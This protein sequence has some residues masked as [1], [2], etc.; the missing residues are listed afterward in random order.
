MIHAVWREGVELPDCG[1]WLDPRQ[2]V[3]FAFIS[4]AHSDHTAPHKRVLC[5]TATAR[6]IA[7]R[8]GPADTVFEEMPYRTPREFSGFRATLLPAGHVPGSAMLYLQSETGSLLYTG[9]FKLRRGLNC[10]AAELCNAETLIMETTYGLPQYV[11]PPPEEVLAD[12]INFC[13]AAHADNEIPVLLGYSLG[14]AQELLAALTAEHFSIL[15]HPS[16]WKVTQLVQ[17]LDAARPG[18]IAYPPYQKYEAGASLPDR[19]VLIFPPGAES[20]LRRVPRRRVAAVS[21]WALDPGFVFRSGCDAAFPLSD[22]ASYTDLLRAVEIV[23]PRRV[24]TLHGFATEFA[25]DLRARGIEAWALTA[26]NQLELPLTL[27]VTASSAV[28]ERRSAPLSSLPSPSHSH[29][30]PTANSFAAFASLCARIRATQSKNEKVR[31][32]AQ[33]LRETSPTD[34]PVV[35]EWISGGALAPDK[36]SGQALQIGSAV[37]R[38]AVLSASGLSLPAYRTVSRRFND[39]SLAALEIFRD[40]KTF[41]SYTVSEVAEIF[42]RLGAIRGGLAKA[43]TL[44][45][46]LGSLSALE[47]ATVI[48]LL[49]GNLRIGLR[50]GLV[51][52]AIASAFDVSPAA[53]REALLLTGRAGETASLAASGALASVSIQLFRPVQVMLASTADDEAALFKRMSSPDGFEVW[54]EDKLDGIRA[55]LHHTP[56]R[57]EIF[58]RDGAC[59][60]NLFPEIASAARPLN[61]TLVLDGEILAFRN[62]RPLDFALLQRR[63]GRV[64][65]DLFLGGE[66][67]VVFRAFD[68]LHLDGKD[69]WREPL[70]YRRKLLD[71]LPLEEP[72]AALPI[73]I[74][75]SPSDLASAFLQARARGNEGLVVKNPLSAYAPGRRG[76][77]W[78]KLKKNFATLDVVVV[79]A[80]FGHGKRAGLLSDY[81][82][83]VRGPDGSLLEVGKAY[84][85]LTDSEI[86][87]LT[88][89]FFELEISR[90]GNKL[91]VRPEIVLE[92]AFDSIRPSRRHASGYAL[93]FPRIKRIRTDKSPAE[94]DTLQTVQ[95]LASTSIHPD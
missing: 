56:D 12:I 18:A 68:L 2:A 42:A 88:T 9:D 13:R 25:A 83:A 78:I 54:A 1:L 48:G 80:E 35:A 57:T 72:L 43:A 76:M 45:N 24:L 63:L 89:R 31:E 66:I 14:K 91:K 95:K 74:A 34:L 39:S 51:E 16:V 92:V 49:N 75:K 15:L 81:T 70:L 17:C 28:K 64:D 61:H 10:E 22:H 65:S 46:F 73:Q 52:S 47:I 55:Q 85:G 79:A 7:A 41:S 71:A 69:V 26:P 87:S 27:T 40:R 4:H 90:R 23:Q 53:V 8:F 6:L 33:Y 84:S 36:G 82:F 19:T 21:G 67:P 58:S 50:E 11:F 38:T 93:R 62:G 60:T 3:E 37:I 59:I 44:A 94:I 5:T 30:T 20:T 77:D 32:L 86:E 29:P